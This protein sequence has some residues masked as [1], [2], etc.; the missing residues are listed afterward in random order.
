[1]QAALRSVEY[2][3][4]GP[5]G[6]AI[7]CPPPDALHLLEPFGS[8]VVVRRS[9]EI[10]AHDEPADFCWR[11]ISGCARTVQLMEDGRR[12][13]DEFLWP[14]DLIGIN[15]LETYNSDAEAVT[16]L[17]LRR[18]PRQQV[19]A[20]AST[21]AALALH[22]RNMTL[23]NLRSAHRQIIL[24]GRKTAVEKIASFLIE[25]DRRSESTNDRFVSLPMSRTDIADHLGLSIETVCR[26]LVSL[27]RDGTVAIQRSGIELCDRDA[28][29]EI[30]CEPSP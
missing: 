26:N 15:D 13:I 7:R 28:L 23:A 9:R 5:A 29:L 17:T 20:Q 16:D 21:H 30:A 10:Y 2:S 4:G 22:L 14:G 6:P 11:I 8:T 12:Q 18:Y 19:E 25:M 3:G 1:M 24:L 27:Q